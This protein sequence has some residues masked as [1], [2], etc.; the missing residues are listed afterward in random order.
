MQPGQCHDLCEVP[1]LVLELVDESS[2]PTGAAEALMI[3]R[4]HMVS[5]LQQCPDEMT[6]ASAVFTEAM[7]DQNGSLGRSGR[8]PLS[9]K[10]RDTAFTEK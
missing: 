9:I 1:Q 7:D 5:G 8:L 6:I 2:S 4:V 10:D 3:V